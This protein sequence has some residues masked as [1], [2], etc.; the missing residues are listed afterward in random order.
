LPLVV[1]KATAVPAAFATIELE[2]RSAEAGLAG[3]AVEA[4]TLPS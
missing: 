1:V 2:I 3:S 4:K